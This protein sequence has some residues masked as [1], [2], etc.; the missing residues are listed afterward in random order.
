MAMPSAERVTRVTHQPKQGIW[1]MN[2]ESDGLRSSAR[3]SQSLD[4]VKKMTCDDGGKNRIG[5]RSAVRRR[6]DPDRTKP[7]ALEVYQFL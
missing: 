5:D 2:T 7:L 6:P 4:D 3:F 1:R